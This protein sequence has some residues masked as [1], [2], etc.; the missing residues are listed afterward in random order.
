MSIQIPRKPYVLTEYGAVWFP[1]AVR[2]EYHLQSR[3][4]VC[5]HEITEGY[6]VGVIPHTDLPNFLLHEACAPAEVL[7]K[8]KE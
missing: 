2:R 3:C 7:K 4:A 6:A 1:V 5:E 8:A